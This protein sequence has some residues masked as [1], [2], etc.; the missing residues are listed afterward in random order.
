MKYKVR[1]KTINW[2]IGI[3]VFIF[4]TCFNPWDAEKVSFSISIGDSIYE[5][6]R[7]TAARSSLPWNEDTSISSLTHIITLT[8]GPGDDQSKTIQGSQT[9]SFIVLPGEWTINVVAYLDE[10]AL[11]AVG[12]ATVTITRGSNDT[13]TIKMQAPDDFTVYTV[14]F[15]TDGGT[16]ITSQNVPKGARVQEP[17]QPNKERYSFDGWFRESTYENKWDFD[18][19][20]IYADVE[21]FA[22]WIAEYDIPTPISAVAISGITPPVTG[23][24]PDTTANITTTPADSAVVASVAWVPNHNTFQGAT[25]YR[26]TVK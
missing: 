20:R 14:T 4:T 21:L 26:V 23:A 2:I 16:V 11:V 12:N 1:L 24:R 17:A 19:D 15:N 9:V 8:N 5:L 18:N 3:I 7:S 13:V 10:S 22:K 25:T 6:A